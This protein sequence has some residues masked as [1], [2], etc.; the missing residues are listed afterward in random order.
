MIPLDHP[1]ATRPH[2]VYAAL[3]N[4]CNRACPWCSTYSSPRGSTWLAL[5]AF[6]AALP[7]GLF[8]VQ[9][10]GGEPTMHPQF[11]EFVERARSNPRCSRLVLCTNGVVM[12]RDARLKGWIEELGAPL[13]VKLSINHYL[14]EH[15]KGL[16]Q[17]AAM[18]RDAIRDLGGDRL[19]ILNVRLRPGRDEWVRAAVSDAGL[20]QHANVFDLQRYGLASGETEWDS[21]FLAGQNFRMVNPDGEVFGPDL[22]SRSEA[23]GKLP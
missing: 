21:P 23:M 12:P 22:L 4:H 6:E 9:L 14:L 1:T 13:T 19:L 8:E 20:L 2:R 7:E 17:L 18:T 11:W 15:D 5:E 16:M 10:E 3:T